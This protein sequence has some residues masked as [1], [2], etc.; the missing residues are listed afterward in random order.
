M[1]L[2][3]LSPFNQ[4]VVYIGLYIIDLYCTILAKSPFSKL[5]HPSWP[6]IEPTFE[7]CTMFE[8]K[9]A[10][11]PPKRHYLMSNLPWKNNI[12]YHIPL[13][14]LKSQDYG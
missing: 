14:S 10:A 4:I 6:N 5:F 8:G 9:C 13:E 7:N 2:A 11:D 1:I 3:W 12:S